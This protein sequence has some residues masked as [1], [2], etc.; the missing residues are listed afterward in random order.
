MA[1]TENSVQAR[2]DGDLRAVVSAG[3]FEIKAD[4]PPSAGGGGTGPQPTELLLA[5][6]ASCF[7][8]ALAYTAR[9]RDVMLSGL[10][11]DVTGHYDGPRFDA[12]RITVHAAEPRDEALTELIA[13]ARRVCYVTRTLASPPDVEIVV[14]ARS[15]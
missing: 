10:E 7:T 6:I 5:S 9:K 12:F 15:R 8:L 2:W 11:V 13:A 1:A 3:G 14:G 4:E